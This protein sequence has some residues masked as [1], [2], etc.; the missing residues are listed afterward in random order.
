MTTKE[1]TKYLKTINE[2]LKE[3]LENV[4]SS[5]CLTLD[6]KRTIT[7]FKY[8]LRAK[9]EIQNQEAYH[10]LLIMSDIYERLRKESFGSWEN[11]YL[12]LADITKTEKYLIEILRAI[13]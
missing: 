3:D 9:G 4:F 13:I 1:E 12:Q 8:S 7:E 6:E 2:K 11:G 10:I 5:P